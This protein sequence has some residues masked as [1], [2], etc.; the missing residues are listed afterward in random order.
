MKKK[1]EKNIHELKFY[2]TEKIFGNNLQNQN[3]ASKN[4]KAKV[5][6]KIL[7]NMNY[8]KIKNRKNKIIEE[9]KNLQNQLEKV[10]INILN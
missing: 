8:K 6:Q 4:K 2:K 9:K 1:I 10:G 7:L 3:Q 5:N